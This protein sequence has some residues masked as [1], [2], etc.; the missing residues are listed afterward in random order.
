LAEERSLAPPPP[1]EFIAALQERRVSPL[2]V[3][4]SI[5]PNTAFFNEIGASRTSATPAE[6]RCAAINPMVI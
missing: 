3:G 5:A 2:S 4:R 6:K 1:F